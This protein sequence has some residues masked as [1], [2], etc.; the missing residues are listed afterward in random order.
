MDGD[1][2]HLQRCS[3]LQQTCEWAHSA[4]SNVS[5]LV[6]DA[7]TRSLN[8]SRHQNTFSGHQGLDSFWERGTSKNFSAL[9]ELAQGCGDIS[10][11]QSDVRQISSLS[12]LMGGM[13]SFSTAVPGLAFLCAPNQICNE[14]KIYMCCILFIY[15]PIFFNMCGE[16]TIKLAE[17]HQLSWTEPCICAEYFFVHEA[18]ELYVVFV[19]FLQNATL[20]LYFLPA[21]LLNWGRVHYAIVFKFNGSHFG[22]PPSYI[23]R[24]TGWVAIDHLHNYCLG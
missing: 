24:M 14:S 15:F 17:N 19:R 9:P 21:F 12:H 3:S 23:H 13:F 11:R 5:V 2:T 7:V 22:L 4:E 8:R 10:S 18:L 6:P 16:W 20:I 1:H